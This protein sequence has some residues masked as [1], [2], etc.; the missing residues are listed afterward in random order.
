MIE[1]NMGLHWIEQSGKIWMRR[2][3]LKSERNWVR[4]RRERLCRRKETFMATGEYF[5]GD[6]RRPI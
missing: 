5:Q 6:A 4:R 2:W 1:N 3:N